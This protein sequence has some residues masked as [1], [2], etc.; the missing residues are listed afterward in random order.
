MGKNVG[1][2]EEYEEI[3]EQGNKNV[4]DE[5]FVENTVKEQKQQKEDTKMDD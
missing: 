2:L 3:I 1:L 4:Q 5:N